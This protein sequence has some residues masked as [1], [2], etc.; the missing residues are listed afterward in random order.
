MY[1]FKI[2]G[3]FFFGF[4]FIFGFFNSIYFASGS[5]PFCIEDIKQE[6][7]G[8]QSYHI[9]GLKINTKDCLYPL[10]L[11]ST[12]SAISLDNSLYCVM[13]TILAPWHLKFLTISGLRR[14]FSHKDDFNKKHEGPSS[15]PLH[16]LWQHV[17]VDG[18]IPSHW[19]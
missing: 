6:S 2:L 11:F 4:C 13:E 15:N 7:H 3:S 14:W 1:F 5:M 17:P 19:V 9:G 18:Q 12:V 16:L 10:F 8:G